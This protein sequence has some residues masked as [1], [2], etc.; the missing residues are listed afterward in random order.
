MVVFSAL[1]GCGGNPAIPQVDAPCG[2]GACV[3]P[4][5]AVLT[6]N[7]D[8]TVVSQNS[9]PMLLPGSGNSEGHTMIDFIVPSQ[10]LATDLAVRIDLGPLPTLGTYTAETTAIWSSLAIQPKSARG[11][12]IFNAGNLAVPEGR[13]SL[14]LD[15]LT[16][17]TGHGALAVTMFVL[18][19]TD[20]MGTQTD[21]GPVATED[22]QLSF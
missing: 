19:Y 11:T 1:A 14:D 4:C 9:C 3:A 7:V 6:G 17:S 21:C 13:F 5:T 10:A 16:A 12:C 8:E 20:E 15:S 2:D 22:L 18:P